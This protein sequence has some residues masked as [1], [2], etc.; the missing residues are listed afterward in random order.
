MSNSPEK[1]TDDQEHG[2]E[3]A[4]VAA[5]QIE[6]LDSQEKKA[7]YTN[8]TEKAEEAKI[9]ALKTAISS[10]KKAEEA[11]KANSSSSRTLRG[12]IGKKQSDES[13]K[14]TMNE[15]RQTM[16]PSDR[17]FSK[18]IHNKAIEKTSEVLGN[19]IARP[20]AIL[21]GAFAAFILTLTIYI[22]AKN[23]GYQLSG[24]ETIAAFII[25]WIIGIIYDYLRII[26]TGKK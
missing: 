25:G 15:T 9:E 26:I 11:E 8:S 22:I 13:F 24:F 6:K 21:S 3:A 12:P 16:S 10:E 1:F 23:I 7:E 17:A 2:V 19:S 14:K 5:E 20:D 4:D 18:I